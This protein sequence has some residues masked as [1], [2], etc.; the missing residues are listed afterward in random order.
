MTNPV[1]FMIVNLEAGGVG[2]NPCFV[3]MCTLC[4]L[5]MLYTKAGF[6]QD[7]HGRMGRQLERKGWHFKS[8]SMAFFN[9]LSLCPFTWLGLLWPVLLG[10]SLPP[11]EPPF[12]APLAL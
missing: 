7:G 5:R 8:V 2:G 4:L 9:P 12:T 1:D 11:R 10:P 3:N 6:H